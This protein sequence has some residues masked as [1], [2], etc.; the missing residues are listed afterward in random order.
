MYLGMIWLS[1][2]GTMVCFMLMK[3]SLKSGKNIWNLK[4][5]AVNRIK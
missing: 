5:L 2:K 1:G 3:E 4:R